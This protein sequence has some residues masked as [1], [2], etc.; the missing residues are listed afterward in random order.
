MSAIVDK[1]V[2]ERQNYN[3][4]NNIYTISS[5]KRDTEMGQMW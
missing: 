3:V 2:S 5:I 4:H 1:M